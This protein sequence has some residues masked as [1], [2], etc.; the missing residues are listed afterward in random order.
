MKY[1]V[2]LIVLFLS[3][4]TAQANT[5]D[6]RSAVHSIEKLEKLCS[7]GISY[8]KFKDSLAD[9]VADFS[10]FKSGIDSSGSDQNTALIEAMD[11]AIREYK[12]VGYVWSL[13]FH[14]SKVNEYIDARSNIGR[15][16]LGNFKELDDYK[17]RG[18][19]LVSTGVRGDAI[20][21]DTAV[22]LLM[23]HAKESVNKVLQIYSIRQR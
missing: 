8:V 5:D 12:T 7:A 20:H 17:H 22:V 14:G 13:K 1:F 6:K 4:S 10:I 23:N 16:L 15:D 18:G 3:V 21:I 2:I 19:A 9:T 11:L